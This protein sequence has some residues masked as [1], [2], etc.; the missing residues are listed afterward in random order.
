MERRVVARLEAEKKS[1]VIVLLSRPPRLPITPLEAVGP[2]VLT[3][4]GLT[5]FGQ[6]T[7]RILSRQASNISDST[8]DGDLGKVIPSIPTLEV[9]PRSHRFT[10]S[11]SSGLDLWSQHSSALSSSDMQPLN[12]KND[13]DGKNVLSSSETAGAARAERRRER[14]QLRKLL[15]K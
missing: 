4:E 8:P 5:P 9:L 10:L 15:E 1:K 2:G 11:H 6:T 3:S 14:L 7:T 13:G 12:D